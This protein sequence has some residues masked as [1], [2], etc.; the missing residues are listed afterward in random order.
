MEVE[1]VGSCAVEDVALDGT[2]KSFGMS[3][4]DAELVGASA[5][6]EEFDASRRCELIVGEGGFS[7][8]VVND[9]SRTV[10]RIFGKG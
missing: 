2:A 10:E 9:L 1:A 5:F 4:V 6:G 7:K 8:T 3:A